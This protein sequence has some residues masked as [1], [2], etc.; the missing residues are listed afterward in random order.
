MSSGPDSIAPDKS[1]GDGIAVEIGGGSVAIFSHGPTPMSLFDPRDGRIVEVND[2]WVERYGYAREEA[3]TLRVQDVS[4]EPQATTNAVRGAEETG[5]ALISTRWHKSK[6]GE[7]FPVE[8]TSGTLSVGGRMLMY[9]VMHD[10]APRLRSEERLSQSEAR[11]RALVE[12]IPIGVLVHRHGRV[13][14][15][16]PGL[17]RLLGYELG[18]DLVGTELSSLVD[19]DDWARVRQRVASVMNEHKPTPTMESRMA[20]KDGRMVPVQVNGMP[21]V[22]DGEP[23]VMAMVMDVRERKQMEAQLVLADRLASL[24]RLAASV[25][26]EINNPLAYLLGNVQLL[27]RDIARAQGLDAETRDKLTER[28]SVLTEGALRVR[29]IVR[30]LKSL[31][32]GE[33]DLVQGTDLHRV[34]EMCVH[35]A[36]HEIRHRAALLR[37]YG[38]SVIVLASEPRLGQVFLNLLVNAAQAIPEGVP[39]EH[40]ITLRTR[41]EGSDRVRI[42]VEDT[43]RGIDAEHRERIF[44]P[45][46]TTKASGG[47]GLG[48][49]ISHSIVTGLGG[50]ISV[51]PAPGRGTRFVVVLPCRPVSSLPAPPASQ[52]PPSTLRS[53]PRLLLAEDE[54][55]LAKTLAAALDDCEV[56]V[57][58]SGNAAIAQLAERRFDAVVLDLHMQDGTGADVSRWLRAH[59]PELTGRVVFMTGAGTEGPL[60]AEARGA[61]LLR[62]PFEY[63]SLR[64]ELQRL[65]DCP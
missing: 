19:E 39:D 4:A 56:T 16:N 36:E 17:L 60:V 2:A 34:L 27:E 21:F 28:L 38:P 9:A 52:K 20:R 40:E 22:Y 10:I 32:G 61:P 14:Y 13:L 49:S 42:E 33:P 7:V 29:D 45:F 54:E 11:F 63:E 64:S 3:R 6:A 8:I 50:T 58:H 1:R 25:G 47:T 5:G 18:D 41:R 15:A 26:H 12:G 23:A 51:E 53:R 62:K 30:D 55:R 43:G 35:M 31:S 57:V 46:F 44:E 48:L 59:R 37:D 65:I 24:G